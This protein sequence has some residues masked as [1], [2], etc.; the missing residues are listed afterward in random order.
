[1][2][3]L[4]STMYTA[5][6]GHP[7]S[8]SIMYP[9][10]IMIRAK[11]QL[12]IL[13]FQPEYSL[14]ILFWEQQKLEGIEIN[15]TLSYR[16]KNTVQAEVLNWY[17]VSKCNPYGQWP[18]YKRS[19]M[20]QDKLISSVFWRYYSVL[21]YFLTCLSWR[22]GRLQLNFYFGDFNQLLVGIFK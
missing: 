15:G 11:T 4:N 17:P 19:L 8:F 10:F 7:W 14:N 20:H 16:V 9:F 13:L 22:T 2:Q 18:I 5:D 3:H 12:C 1:M 21:Y 6:T